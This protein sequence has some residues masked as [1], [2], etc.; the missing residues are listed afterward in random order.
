[1]HVIRSIRANRIE[2][3]RRIV[4]SVKFV[5]WTKATVRR[6]LPFVVWNNYSTLKFGDSIFGSKRIIFVESLISIEEIWP[7]LMKMILKF[8][9]GTPFVCN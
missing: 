1:M 3:K 7:N 6:E 9:K 2:E 8:E 5:H 4:V